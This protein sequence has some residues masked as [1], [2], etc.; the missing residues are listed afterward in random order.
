MVASDILAI[1]FLMTGLRYTTSANASLLSNFEI[2][3]TSLIAFLFFKEK[4]SKKLAF[5]IF[6]VVLAGIILT[7][8]NSS[9]VHF[10]LGSVMVLLS[11][12]L[13]GLE[14]NATRMMSSKNTMEITIIKGLCAGF[15][16]LI[17]ALLLNAPV[18]ALKYVLLILFIG[19]LC[20]GFSVNMYI[21]AQKYLKASITAVYFAFNPYFAVIFSFLILKEHL[22]LNFIVA[23]L[24]ML[25][26]VFIVYKEET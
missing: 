25:S 11:Y 18:P 9:S 1:L 16:S 2:V 6:L 4:I 15:G 19:F 17:I 24:I 8:E 23:F 22:S 5:G 7:F 20:Y 21:M 10:R 26:A 14:N 13:W 3:A 12:L